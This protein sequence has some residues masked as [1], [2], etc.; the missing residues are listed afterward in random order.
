MSMR[1]EKIA[2]S[3]STRSSPV[4]SPSPAP[5]K[6]SI[7]AR[8][9]RSTVLG[10]RRPT[11]FTA[12]RML[13]MRLDK[14]FCK[15]A[16]SVARM[17]SSSRRPAL[18]ALRKAGH[19]PST[20]SASSAAC[21]TPGARSTDSIPTSSLSF[22]SLANWRYSR[23]YSLARA[24][25]TFAR[26]TPEFA[27]TKL[28]RKAT[29]PRATALFTSSRTRLS[30]ASSSRGRYNDNSVWRRFTVLIST[31]NFAPFRVASPRPY[32]VMEFMDGKL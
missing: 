1:S 12:L 15:C 7:N 14:S 10:A 5:L 25:F 32:P 22:N 16:P 11:V 9:W 6:R 13:A 30:S 28:M 26:P 23:A 8:R 17:A 18:N 31:V 20:S 29:R 27:G 2:T 24:T 4:S 21:N 3:L 19:N